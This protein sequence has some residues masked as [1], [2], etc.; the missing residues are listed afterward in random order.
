MSEVNDYLCALVSLASTAIDETNANKAKTRERLKELGV[1]LDDDAFDTVYQKA[2]DATVNERTPVEEKLKGLGERERKALEDLEMTTAKEFIHGTVRAGLLFSLRASQASLVGN[3]ISAGAETV[4]KVPAVLV[5]MMVAKGT[6]ERTVAMTSPKHTAG[7]MKHLPADVWD[8]MKGFVRGEF[9][10]KSGYSAHDRK[11]NYQPAK[12]V[13]GDRAPAVSAV[14]DAPFRATSWVANKVFDFIEAV[15]YPFRQQA[16]RQAVVEVATLRGIN[17]GYKGKELA[18]YVKAMIGSDGADFSIPA[19]AKMVDDEHGPVKEIWVESK[20]LEDQAVFANSSEATNLVAKIANVPGAVIVLPFPKIPT[21]TSLRSLEYSPAGAVYGAAKAGKAI[22]DPVK[23]GTTKTLSKGDQR[24]GALAIGR[25]VTGAGLVYLGF[26][27]AEAFGTEFIT[28]PASAHYQERESEEAQGL[29]GSSIRIGDRY[30]TLREYPQLITLFAGAALFES[31]QRTGK[32]AMDA[33]PGEMVSATIESA[34]DMP[35]LQGVQSVARTIQEST[36]DKGID[37]YA[38]SRS[39]GGMVVPTVATDIAAAAKGD[40]ANYRTKS[41]GQSVERDLA[42]YDNLH[43]RIDAFGQDSKRNIGWLAQVRG[44]SPDLGD[45]LN[46]PVMKEL[47]RIKAKTEDI[48]PK[49]GETPEAFEFRAKTAGEYLYGDLKNVIE[50]E[51]WR[52]PETTDN[53]RLAEVAALK[54]AARRDATEDAKA[55]FPSVYDPEEADEE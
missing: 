16:F 54:S 14:V 26:K 39:V 5:D 32:S 44:I 3:L 55:K 31:T 33:Y 6:G 15:D 12:K 36:T 50:S 4:A 34:L 1:E 7:R 9:E 35:A 49:K 43:K 48:R 2:L 11:L 23:K 53:E 24:A 8:A 13:L 51:W 22:V 17:E 19:L 52:S 30:Y 46:D 38:L 47:R 37:E 42:D 28:A 45:K 29:R 27:L 41:F 21:N 25:S 10:H 40:D 18:E 20:E